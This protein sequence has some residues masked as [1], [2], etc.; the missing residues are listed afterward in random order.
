MK[1][2]VGCV[3]NF[4]MI[5][6]VCACVNTTHKSSTNY[7]EYEDV[8]IEEELPANQPVEWSPT[9]GKW[10][11]DQ[12][13]AIL[14]LKYGKMDVFLR[15]YP[16]DRFELSTPNGGL[17]DVW[18]KIKDF[19]GN[20]INISTN[21]A[22]HIQGW[23]RVE[24]EDR[25][26]VK[27]LYQLL[28]QGD[29]IVHLDFINEFKIYNEGCGLAEFVWHKFT[30]HDPYTNEILGKTTSDDCYLNTS[31]R[32]YD[33]NPESGLSGDEAMDLLIRGE[34]GDEEATG[35]LIDA[36]LDGLLSM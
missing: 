5:F 32:V 27:R 31:S 21:T 18:F 33:V 7:S 28:E 35:Q 20:T 34:L 22:R 30:K 10:E 2:I 17:D 1:L 19:D 36:V 8:D 9:C 15:Y 29:F 23:E 25:N 24:I 26:S 3:L 6:M 4:T 14:R 11:M 13:S 12:N 16:G